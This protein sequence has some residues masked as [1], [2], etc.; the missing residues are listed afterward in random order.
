MLRVGFLG[1]A[2]VAELHANALAEI[3]EAALA[4]VWSRT[5][6][7]ARAFADRHGTRAYDDMDALL[8][9]DGIDAVFV[10]TV[11]ETHAEFAGRALAAG[12]HVLVEKPLGGSAAEVAELR[13]AAAASGKVCMPSHNYIYC[14]AA[15]RMKAHI[16]AGRIGRLHS[17]WTL[18]NQGHPKDFGAPDVLMRELMIH[19]VYA[20]VYFAGRPARLN[21]TG[22]NSHFTDPAAHDQ[23]MLSCTYR[24]GTIGNVWGSFAADDRSRD[25]WT[26]TFKAIG[27]DGTASHSWDQIKWEGEHLPGWDDAAYTDSFLF[28]QRHFV[29]LCAGGPPPL[30]TMD[31]AL[32][33]ADIL[34]AARASLATGRAVE[35]GYTRA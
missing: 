31:D 14:E 9:D 11:S 19:P 33:C 4:G 7:N 18:Y 24:D 1:S 5:A 8:A 29:R 27:A 23:I 26:V 16:D 32:A 25:P 30:S 17:V 12:K 21:A 34:D 28:A 35:I 20:M 10:L 2:G 22:T 13:R 3:P 15:Q 6:A